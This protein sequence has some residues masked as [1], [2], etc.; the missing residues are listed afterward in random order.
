MRAWGEILAVGEK[1]MMLSDGCG[2]LS[3]AI[4]VSLDL[5]SKSCLGLC[6]WCKRFCWYSFNRVITRIDFADEE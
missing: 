2:D 6:V 5:K 3:R 4:A 1:V